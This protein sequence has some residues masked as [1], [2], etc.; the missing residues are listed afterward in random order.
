LADALV[1]ALAESLQPHRS[2][3][4]PPTGRRGARP[5]EITVTESG[6]QIRRIDRETFYGE[7]DLKVQHFVTNV[8][9]TAIRDTPRPAFGVAPPPAVRVDVKTIDYDMLAQ[10][11]ISLPAC[12]NGDVQLH[13]GKDEVV[14]VYAYRKTHGRAYHA[15]LMLSSG[16]DYNASLARFGVKPVQA[17]VLDRLSFT[18]H[19]PVMIRNGELCVN[20]CDLLRDFR[21]MQNS[22]SRRGKPTGDELHL[23]VHR[24]LWTMLYWLMGTPR[25]DGDAPAQPDEA[26][27]GLRLWPAGLSLD[28]ALSGAY[29]TSDVITV[30]KS[31]YAY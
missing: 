9:Q 19:G 21:A 22:R 16:S 7:A 29:S 24:M 15:F 13:L 23:E 30:G 26:L 5:L 14:D 6:V 10:L 2:I 18:G 31:P 8:M 17:P 28:A 4:D 1:T 3:V 25:P 12:S 11:V 27:G 20:P